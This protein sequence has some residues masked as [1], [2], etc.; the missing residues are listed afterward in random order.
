MSP[1]RLFLLLG[2]LSGMISV[3][4]G[5][6][7]AHLLKVR[8]AAGMLEIFETAV[9]YQMF[10]A[11]ALVVVAWAVGRFEG[12]SAPLAGV[13]FAIGSVL[14]CGSLYAYSL[15]GLRAFTMGAPFGGAA[16]AAGWACLAWTAL[17]AQRRAH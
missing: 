10:H 1:D 16:L 8:L 13:L 11:L 12:R 9:R 5:A 15:S 4:A 2:A 17:A 14:F 3:L 6:L 7:G